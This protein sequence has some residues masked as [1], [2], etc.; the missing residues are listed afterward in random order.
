MRNGISTA[1]MVIGYLVLGAAYLFDLYCASILFGFK[2]I[3][4]G[5]VLFP[6]LL[7]ATPFYMAFKY[8]VW[9]SLILTAIGTIIVIVG[10]ATRKD[11]I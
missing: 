2:G 7:A 1:I 3:A 8:G 4:V 11:N 6:V 9:L 10:A 5:L